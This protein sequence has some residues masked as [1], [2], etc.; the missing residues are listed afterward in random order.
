MAL[1]TRTVRLTSIVAIDENGAIGCRN[2]L[3]W[4]LKSDMAFFRQQTTGNA[5]IMGRKTY[6][7]IGGPLPHRENIVLSHNDVL[8]ADT[9]NCQLAS[10][11]SEALF[12]ANRSKV[13]EIFVIGGAQTYGQFSSLVERYLV[14]I[15]GHKAHDAD[16]FLNS[17]ILAD[18]GQWGRNL[19]RSCPAT[20]GRDDHSFDIFEILPPNIDERRERQAAEVDKVQAQISRPTPARKPKNPTLPFHQQAFSF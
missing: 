19:V 10:S 16:A 4:S 8:F 3:P 9:P 12:K 14:T 17:E 18:I 6:D 2:A 11:V 20:L 13:S 5:V 7:S 1:K 15:V